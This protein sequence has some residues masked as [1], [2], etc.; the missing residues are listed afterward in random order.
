MNIASTQ[1][2]LNTESFEIYVSG[3]YGN[4]KGCFNPI[5]KD[6]SIGSP[7]VLQLPSIIEKIKENDLVIKKIWILGG[8]PLDQST[9]ELVELLNALKFLNKE[10]W[11]YTRHSLESVDNRIKELCDYI[12]CGEYREDLRTEDNIQYGIKIA[13]SNQKINKKGLD[14]I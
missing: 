9:D 6:F 1:Y 10:L 13:S 14:F 2:S 11:V 12:K 4:C 5:L 3:C 7:L 8:E